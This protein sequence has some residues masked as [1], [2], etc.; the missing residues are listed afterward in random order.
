MDSPSDGLNPFLRSASRFRAKELSVVPD[1]LEIALGRALGPGTYDSTTGGSYVLDVA[2]DRNMDEVSAL[3]LHVGFEVDAPITRVESGFLQPGG[4]G[5]GIDGS[6]D[7]LAVVVEKESNVGTVVRARPPV[8]VPR[9][10]QGVAFLRQKRHQREE[11]NG[12]QPHRHAVY[13][14]HD[15]CRAMMYPVR[16]FCFLMVAGVALA[17]D[18]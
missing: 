15:R 6:S 1:D 3:I 11:A 18:S 16:G 13:L 2:V 7:V 12:K 10:N 4:I 14:N 8:S 9:A 5:A 17:Q